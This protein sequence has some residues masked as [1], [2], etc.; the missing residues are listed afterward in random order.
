MAPQTNQ[1]RLPFDKLTPSG[2]KSVLKKFEKYECKVAD[3][4]STNKAKRESGILIKSF[5]LKFED[6]Q[7]MEVRVKADGTVFQVKLNKK[8]VPIHNVDNIDKAVIELVNYVQDN[9]KAYEKAKIQRQKRKLVPPTPSIITTRR[10]KIEKAKAA[11]Q[12]VSTTNSQ[13]ESQ[14]NEIKSGM[15]DKQKQLNDAEKALQAERD[16]TA[17]LEAQIAALQKEQGA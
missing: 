17:A 10:E 3:V 8:V 11:L 16:T 12:E 5:T 1:V 13:L 7:Q 15:S 14:L 4:E 9:A 6:G 2:L